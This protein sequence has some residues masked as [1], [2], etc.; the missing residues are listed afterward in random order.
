MMTRICRQAGKQAKAS[1]F[2]AHVEA[3]RQA[4]KQ[5]CRHA[6]ASSLFACTA[7]NSRNPCQQPHACFHAP[8]CLQLLLHPP[9]GRLCTCMS[10]GL[11][12]RASPADGLRVHIMGHSARQAP[13]IPWGPG[14]HGAGPRGRPGTALLCESPL[15]APAV[16]VPC[17]PPPLLLR[18]ALCGLC[19]R[20]RQLCIQVLLLLLLVGCK[21]AGAHGAVGE[22]ADW[23]ALARGFE[24]VRR[25]Q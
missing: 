21:A 10:K 16:V 17:L 24:H 9:S 4:G 23:P 15:A 12:A 20:G 2:L 14:T 25:T 13:S 22:G 1:T 7:S 8:C 5:V 19:A 6:E 18:T 11:R 3:C